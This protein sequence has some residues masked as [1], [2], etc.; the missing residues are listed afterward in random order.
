MRITLPVI[1]ATCATMAS[2][3]TGDAVRIEVLPGSR[4]WIEGSSNLGDW[5]CKASA[6]DARVEIDPAHATHEDAAILA[7]HVQR[8]TVRVSVRDLKCGNRKMERDLYKALKAEDPA[9]PS[10][11]LGVFSAVS[12]ADTQGGF[13]DTEGP[14]AVAGAEKRARVRIT[15]DRLPDGI[16]RAKGSVP[17]LMTDFGVKPPTGLFGL[18]RSRNEVE[19][20]FELVIAV[21]AAQAP[22]K[23]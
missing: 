2:A 4:V 8:V 23:E 18:V 16:V 6:F 14:I 19:V 10:E 11:I 9:I 1:L 20:K 21:R 3:Q 12:D 15:M 17:L 13:L 7:D 22:R 5:A